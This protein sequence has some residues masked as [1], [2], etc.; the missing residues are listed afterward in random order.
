MLGLGSKG[1]GSGFCT[2]CSMLKVYV[3]MVRGQRLWSWSGVRGQ[4]KGSS[5]RVKGLGIK[6]Q[7]SGVNVMG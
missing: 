3:L 4:G 7:W 1:Q 5:L 2:Q 6:G